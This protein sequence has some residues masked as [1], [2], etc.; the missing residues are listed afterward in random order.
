MEKLAALYA[1]KICLPILN[2]L[3][4]LSL[5]VFDAETG[6]ASSPV[7]INIALFAKLFIQ[8]AQVVFNCQALTWAL[9]HANIFGINDNNLSC[10]G[11]IVQASLAADTSLH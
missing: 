7:A 3:V 4:L 2:G 1:G 9:L 6:N 5:T 8:A 10:P 11:N